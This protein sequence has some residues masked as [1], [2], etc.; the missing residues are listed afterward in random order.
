MDIGA[1]TIWIGLDLQLR[2]VFI[3]AHLQF[4]ID[5]DT[6]HID[7]LMCFVLNPRCNL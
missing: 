4:F 5:E 2:T 6:G 7:R 3:I 1:G